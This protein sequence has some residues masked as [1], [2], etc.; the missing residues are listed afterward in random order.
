MKRWLRLLVMIIAWSGV[1]ACVSPRLT[2][3]PRL[4]MYEQSMQ[5]VPAA[6]PDQ[7]LRVMTINLAHGRGSGLHQAFQDGERARE[8]LDA[9]R[10]VIQ[11]EAPQVVALQEADAASVWSGAF[12]HVDYLASSTG[13]ASGML[14]VHAEGGGQMYGTALLT[15]LPVIEKRAYTFV[16]APATFPKGFSLLTVRWPA[17]GELVDVVSLHLEP[18]RSNVRQSQARQLIAALA[19]R[20]RPLVVMG[21]FN[22]E[23]GH[24]DGVLE[25]IINDLNLQTFRQE[26]QDLETF[27]RLGRRLDWILASQHFE[28]AGFTVLPERLSDHRAVVALLRPRFPEPELHSANQDLPPEQRSTP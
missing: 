6:I 3:E 8:N 23:W 9:V 1:S 13:F 7:T 26:A 10:E 2:P 24:K 4:H 16:P 20:G 25:S 19:D 17:N 28:F 27:P 12:D 22:T 5:L 18:L 14:A 21:D 15:Q 11:R